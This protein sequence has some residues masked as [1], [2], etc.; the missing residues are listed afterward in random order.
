MS[1]VAIPKAAGDKTL[2]YESIS[3]TLEFLEVDCCATRR[4]S[5]LIGIGTAIETIGS[6]LEQPLKEL[7]SRSP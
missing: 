4:V 1:Q 5:Q 2:H 6:Q 3:N 7:Y